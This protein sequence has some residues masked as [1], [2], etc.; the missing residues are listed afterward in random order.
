MKRLMVIALAAIPL[1]AHSMEQFRAQEVQPYR[2]QEVQPQR[3]SDISPY[4]AN[5]VEPRSPGQEKGEGRPS[6]KRITAE[7]LAGLWQTNVPGAV[8]T[9]PGERPG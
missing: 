7:E 8:Y 4:R 3:G 1:P 6:V 5:E 2:A 9:T